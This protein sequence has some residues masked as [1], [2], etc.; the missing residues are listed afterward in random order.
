MPKTKYGKYIV[1]KIKRNI[2][3]APWNPPQPT[4]GKN[5]GGR[6][7]FLDS[8]VVE[9]AFYMECTWVLPRPKEDLSRGGA[10]AHTHDYDEVI[11]FFGTN[12]E[13]F[14][15]LGAEFEL[16]LGDEKHVITK[17]FIAFIPSGLSHGPSRFLRVDRPVFHVTTGPGKMYF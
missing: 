12:P 3:E 17:S 15:D 8:Q 14:H 6:F 2:V 4:A 1:T 13:D 7:L 9:G 10:S 5:T 11:A 16:W